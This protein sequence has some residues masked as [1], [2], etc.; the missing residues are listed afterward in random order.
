MLSTLLIAVLLSAGPQRPWVVTKDVGNYRAGN[1]LDAADAGTPEV[2]EAPDAG[3]AD[4][5]DEDAAKILR[6]L[7]L[8]KRVYSEVITKFKTL[9]TVE[10][11][12]WEL[13]PKPDTD[14]AIFVLE[15]PENRRVSLVFI[16]EK[17]SWQV[18]PKTFVEDRR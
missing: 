9:P 6:R 11:S 1:V 16:Y 15:F 7:Q 14:G 18:I 8:L 13:N 2:A 3:T 17:G 4:I 12:S 5:S 10:S